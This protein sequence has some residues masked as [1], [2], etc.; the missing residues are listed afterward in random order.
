M[1][2]I[3]MLDTGNTD[4]IEVPAGWFIEIQEPAHISLT[5]SE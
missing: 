1:G 3:V 5:L 4:I 2:D